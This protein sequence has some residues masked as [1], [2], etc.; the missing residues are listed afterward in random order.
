MT[1]SYSMQ[2][3]AKRVCIYYYRNNIMVPTT[4]TNEV[5]AIL[6]HAVGTK[7]KYRTV[8]MVMVYY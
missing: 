2:N 8:Y 1:F 3:E 5:T 4:Y 6:K 7:N